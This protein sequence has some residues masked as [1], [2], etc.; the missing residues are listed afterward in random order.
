MASR[1]MFSQHHKD[2]LSELISVDTVTP[3]ESG[4]CCDLPRALDLYAAAAQ[5]IGFTTLYRHVPTLDCEAPVSVKRRAEEMGPEFFAHQASIVLGS[6]DIHGCADVMFNFHMD[7]VGPFFPVRNLRGGIHGRGAADNK[8]P[9]VAILEG[10]E[11]WAA[12]HPP[13]KRRPRLLIQCVAGEE[14]GAMGVY[15]T[16]QLMELGYHGSL[17]IFAIPSGGA[18]FDSSTCSMTLELFVDG[19][20]ATDD[21]PHRGDNASLILSYLCAELARQMGPICSRTDVRMTLAGVATGDMHNRVYGTG[22]AQFNFSYRTTRSGE[23]VKSAV[24]SAIETAGFRFVDIFGGIDVFTRTAMRLD[25]ILTV[26]WLKSGLPVLTNRNADW[27]R[28]LADAGIK[29]HADDAETFTCDAMWGQG[30][31]YSIMWGP[32]SLST[33]GAH[34]SSEH[35]DFADLDQFADQV[36]ALLFIASYEVT[37]AAACQ[38]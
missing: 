28:K 2:L 35:I 5:R 37:G 38:T 3:M 27:E 36:A 34:T 14:G 8:G 10:I 1:S 6:Q 25:Q 21:A 13:E 12:N 26:R 4:R 31:G 24:T 18:Y 33:N 29:R 22:R 20:G 32:G 9:G 19:K 30:R 15:G 17:N 7:T 11:R 23:L 16:K